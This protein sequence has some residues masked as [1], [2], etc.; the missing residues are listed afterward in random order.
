MKTLNLF[1]FII[2]FSVSKIFSQQLPEITLE[3]Y[4]N[5]ILNPAFAAYKIY[6]KT[7]FFQ[8]KQ[9]WTGINEA[10]TL[11]Y[12]CGSMFINNYVGIGTK[13]F[14]FKTG[15]FNR[16]GI[17]LSYGVRFKVSENDLMSLGFS[18]VL[19]QLN[20]DKS[21]VKIYENFDKVISESRDNAIYPDFNF[22]MLYYNDNFFIGLSVMQLL[23]N[24]S[25]LFNEKLE[26]KQ[27]RHYYAQFS[28]KY[29]LLDFYILA[30]YVNFRFVNKEIWQGK[31][32]LL[33]RIYN[34]FEIGLGYK[35]SKE[36]SISF[37]YNNNTII[38]G[39]NYDIPFHDIK[40]HTAGSHE[41]IFGYNFGKAKNK[42]LLSN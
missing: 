36:F 26:N 15:L 23:N 28:T 29:E 3:Y 38:A 1:V 9:L 35:T 10:P 37:V 17:E 41:I 40:K 14:N 12:L 4:N 2:L 18:A 33:N 5:L 30:P 34:S 42:T 25:N 13:F 39:Y 31:I 7:V 22:G 8:H 24:S 32:S 27:V 11:Q 6:D 20:F 21:K 19:Y 16:Q